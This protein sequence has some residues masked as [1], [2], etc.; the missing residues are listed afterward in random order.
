MAGASRRFEYEVWMNPPENARPSGWRSTPPPQS[1]TEHARAVPSEPAP[2]SAL[3]PRSALDRYKRDIHNQLIKTLDSGRLGALPLD[4]Q[5]TELRTML[6][7]AIAAEPPPVPRSEYDQVITDLRFRDDDHVRQVIDRIVVRVNRRVDESS[8]MVDA[9]LPDGSRVNAIIPPL[10]LRGPLISIRRFS[11][12]AKSLDDL[13]QLLM[14]T[15][16]MSA[17]MQAAVKARL[18]IVISG[19]TGSGKTTLLNALSHSIPDTERVVTIEDSAELKLQQRHVLPLES[20][21]ANLE[22]KGEVTVR[23]LVRNALRMRPDRIVI[24]ECR[25]AEALDMLQAMNTGHDG[26]LTTLHANNSRDVLARLE[27]MVMM[28]G[29]DLPVRVIRQQIAG[30]IDLIV[31]TNRLQGG[32]R[33]VT[34]ITELVGMEQETITLQDLFDYHQTGVS[35]QGKAVGMFRATGVRPSFMERFATANC[36]VPPDLFTERIL[37]RDF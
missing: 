6:T 14:L 35:G 37:L 31:Q 27:T 7:K 25:G 9:R 16:E 1:P 12:K 29:Y 19:G 18:N 17:F 34:A 30:A 32:V 33:R 21:P 3:E 8:P 5:R 23:D 36:P 11:G 22:G 26:S 28:A 20:R 2:L 10:S 24:G 4:R 15:P 13:T